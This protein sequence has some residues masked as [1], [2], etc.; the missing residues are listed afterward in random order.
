MKVCSMTSTSKLC[1][2]AAS[3]A[4]LTF[5]PLTAAPKK[6]GPKLVPFKGKW[7]GVAVTSTTTETTPEGV[8]VTTIE[9][10]SEGGGNATHLGRYTMDSVTTST[11]ET[12][13][14]AGAQ[15]F[16]A[17]N[18]DQVFATITGEF[19][20]GSDGLVDGE[21]DATITGGTGRFATSTGYYTFRVT[22]DP[23]T[24][25]S[26]ASFTGKISGPGKGN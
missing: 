15:V 10:T 24:G 6:G 20:T 1:V 22:T 26:V 2:L 4:L 21:F 14:S 11:S 18:G 25:K 16:T 23:D 7:M 19:V 9:E 17:A 3:L 5:S 13:L 8:V 12:A